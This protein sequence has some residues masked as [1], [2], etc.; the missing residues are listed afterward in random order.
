VTP[1]KA[2]G[3]SGSL[4][5]W[6]KVVRASLANRGWTCTVLPEKHSIEALGDEVCLGSQS[7]KE[8]RYVS[9]PNSSLESLAVAVDQPRQQP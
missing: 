7:K 5:Q 8:R 9:V 2:K 6:K 1:Y 4:R 3:S